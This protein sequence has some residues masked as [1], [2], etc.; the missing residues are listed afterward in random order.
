[1]TQDAEAAEAN[2]R[3]L[4]QA[5]SSD[6]IQAYRAALVPNPVVALMIDLDGDGTITVLAHENAE[7][8]VERHL[9]ETLPPLPPDEFYCIVCDDRNEAVFL[10]T[11]RLDR[12]LN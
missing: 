8:L 3:A 7:A 10:A 1:M 5:H 4:L 11:L 12:V 6:L 2:A 9:D